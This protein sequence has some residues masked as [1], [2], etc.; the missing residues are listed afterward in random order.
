MFQWLTSRI[1]LHGK[2]V[3]DPFKVWHRI[4][5]ITSE[6]LSALGKDHLQSRQT[7]PVDTKGSKE[8]KKQGNVRN[9]SQNGNVLP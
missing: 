2:R 4:H 8:K 6:R 3:S 7:V 5:Y 9:E 1:R